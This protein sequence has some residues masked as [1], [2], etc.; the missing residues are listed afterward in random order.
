MLGGIARYQ[1]AGKVAES[2]RGVS[3]LTE[4]ISGLKEREEERVTGSCL[5]SGSGSGSGS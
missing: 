5:S 4:I 1:L 2:K 3:S